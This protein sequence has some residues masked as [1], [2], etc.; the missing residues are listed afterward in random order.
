MLL[1]SGQLTCRTNILRQ[2]R[3]VNKKLAGISKT[4]A[5]IAETGENNLDTLVQTKK[6][7]ADQRAQIEK[8]GQ[9][10][11]QLKE[12]ES[13][14]KAFLDF[15]NDIEARYEK[16]KD[17]LKEELKEEHQAE[18]ERLKEE[19]TQS[20]TKDS[21]TKVRDALQIACHFLHAAAFQRQ[22]EDVDQVE[23]D[24]YEAVLFHLYQGNSAAVDTIASLVDGTDEKIKNNNGEELDY[25]FAQLKSSAM[26]T[27]VE[28]A[29]QQ[30]PTEPA[31]EEPAE[32]PAQEPADKPA[33]DPTLANAG[34]TELEDTATVPATA[35]DE[36]PPS[37]APD[38]ASI[39]EPGNAVAES[40]WN[41]EASMTT[42]NTQ[43]GEDWVQVPRDPAETE[44]GAPAPAAQ[45]S[46]SNWADEAGAAAEENAPTP[47]TEN[48]GFSEVRRDR[49]GRGRGGRGRGF[50]GRGRGRGRGEFRGRG[51]GRGRGGPRGGAPQAQAS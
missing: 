49:G 41:P 50:D 23:S 35:A 38:Q 40:S 8:E 36:E 4:K 28:D 29:D 5:T 9:L 26:S 15:S 14:H 48:D 3:N 39:A 42:D 33:S 25:T 2:I 20:S 6:I 22:K 51:G 34:L 21:Q 7:N 37:A 13:R 10:Q 12:A 43:T 24:A 45:Q 46:T 30:E 1:N 17:A 31:V 19:G 16:Q 11:D 44:T 47:T 32:V 18:I 27:T